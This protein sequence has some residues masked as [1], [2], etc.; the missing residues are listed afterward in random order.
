MPKFAANISLL[1]TE[2]PFLQRLSAAA[3][4]G[5]QGVECQFPYQLGA[6][7]LAAARADAGI[8]LVLHNLP[9]GDWAAGERGIACLPERVAEFHAGVERALEYARALH[10]RQLNCLAG[11]RPTSLS[12]EAAR[13]TLLANLRHAARKLAPHGIRLLLEPINQR[14]VPGFFVHR[15]EQA[16]ALLD[17]LAEP[18]TGLQFDVYH[19][20]VSGEDPAAMLRR[21]LP[22]IAHVQVS[23]EPGRREPGSGEIDFQAVFAALEQGAYRGWVGGEYQPAG[24]TL[25]GLGWMAELRGT[26]PR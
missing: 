9:P 8:P 6:R 2:Q 26:L 1:F 25:S 3:A 18:N 23:D 21:W 22:R 15:T 7:A 16:L 14:D 11:I 4:A 13:E 17:E 20:H 12:E 10:C 24:D 5:F 19:S